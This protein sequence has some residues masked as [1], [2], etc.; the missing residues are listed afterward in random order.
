[1]KEWNFFRLQDCLKRRDKLSIKH[2]SE[3]V[4]KS[5]TITSSR[6]GISIF[7]WAQLYPALVL[8]NHFYGLGKEVYLGGN[9][10][11]YSEES[12]IRPLIP[13]G[14]KIFKSM[15]EMFSYLK[16][17]GVKLE[18]VPD[19]SGLSSERYKVKIKGKMEII[20]PFLFREGCN[21]QCS[22]CIENNRKPADNNPALLAKSAVK[23][24]E[25]LSK[26]HS[27]RY[28]F[29]A[30]CAIDNYPESLGL[31]ADNLR[32]KGIKW[33]AYACITGLNKSL[34]KRVRESGC[35]FLLF[36]VESGSPRM[37]RLMRKAHN[38]TIIKEVLKN[39][40]QAGIYNFCFFIAN[41]PGETEEDFRLTKEF[42]FQNRKIIDDIYVT[43]FLMCTGSHIQK[44][45]EEF[46]IELGKPVTLGGCTYSFRYEGQ[47]FEQIQI[48]TLRKKREL[49]LLAT[50]SLK[51]RKYFRHPVASFRRKLFDNPCKIGFPVER[52][53]DCV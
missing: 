19:F 22:F 1:M 29:F 49:D 35:D 44:H 7:S 9:V 42:I 53:F 14:V 24:I 50:V 37:L 6:V 48:E 47:S 45:P 38:P 31:L 20:L 13:K 28:F 18:N 40:K 25:E 15:E 43:P 33:G 39:S 32:G 27:S 8:A 41:F 12:D 36:G 30:D 2:Y 26:K 23:N 21:K 17:G 52:L 11:G 4:L 10:I 46:G 3:A 51:V 5:L 34:I 16:I